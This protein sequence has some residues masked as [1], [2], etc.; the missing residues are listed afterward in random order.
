MPGEDELFQV[1]EPRACG[2]QEQ[3]GFLAALDFSPPP[4]MRFDFRN[5]IG[6]GDQPR[7]QSGPGQFARDLHIRRGDEH[8]G[9]L[10]R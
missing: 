4:V 7:F 3:Q 2:F 6:A 1:H 9:K 5:Q 10:T 8:D